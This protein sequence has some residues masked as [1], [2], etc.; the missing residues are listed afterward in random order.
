MVTIFRESLSLAIDAALPAPIT[1]HPDPDRFF[2]CARVA[3]FAGLC[4]ILPG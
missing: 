4:F 1:F 2:C 3:D